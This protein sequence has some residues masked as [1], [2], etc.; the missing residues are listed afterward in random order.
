MNRN[1]LRVIA[2]FATLAV[3]AL[4]LAGCGGDEPATA[5][6]PPAPPPAPPP[7]QPQPVEVALGE[8]GGTV[9]LMTVE[10]GGF[11]L[12]G[13]AFE[14]GAENPVE[15]EGG[16]M[17]ALTLA[18]GAWT[19]A[20]VPM[21]IMVALGA[22]EESVTL[23]TVE[24]GGYTM[25]GM[26]VESGGTATS[27]A[28]ASYTL[29]MAEDGTWTA[30]FAP[31]T[32]SVPLGNSGM[33]VE[34]VSNEA[35]MWTVG[36]AALKGDGTDTYMSEGRTYSLAMEDGAWT[37]AFVPMTQDVML[38]TSGD[39]V[40]LMTVES[41]GW[42]MGDSSV[43][44]GYMTTAANGNRY[45]LAMVAGEW[46]ATFQPASVAV[47]L[48]GSGE[49]ATLMT[50]E[51]G[52]WT[53]NGMAL[54]EAP[55]AMNSAGESYSLSMEDGEWTAM[56]VP[57]SQPVT[58]GASGMS[59][60][61]MTDE[62]GA[63]T[64]DGDV[65]DTGATVAGGANAAT[66][67]AN[68]Y[69][70]TLRDDGTWGAAYQPATMPIGDT[71]LQARAKEDG[72]GYDVGDT[73]S[74]DADGMGE[75]TGPDG[76]MFRVMMDADGMLAGVRY[77]LDMANTAMTAD[78]KEFTAGTANAA[79]TLIGNDRD[80]PENEK[81]TRLSALRESFSMGE[82]LGG[83][84]ATE[85][86]A[87]IVA[88]AR[89]EMVKIRD[90]VAQLV[91]LR[92]DDGITDTAFT[93]QIE[94]QW[95]KA[96]D[97]IQDIFGGS[98]QLERTLS[99]SRVVDAFDRLVDALSSE[100]NFLA[101]SLAN[102]PDK[103]QGFHDRTA[104]NV[105]A[106]FNRLESTATARLGALRST[107]FGA[108]VFNST[109]NAKA[110]Y[111]TAEAAQAFAWSTM[112][113]IRRATD[114]TASGE[115]TY[116][117]QTLAAD[118]AGN[119]YS[120][121][122]NLS[123][124]LTRMNVDGFVTQLA[125]ADTQAP[126]TQ[127]LGGEVVGIHFPTAALNTRGR[128]HVES[129]AGSTNTGR[130]S[131]NPQ[132]GGQPDEDLD[133]GATFTGQLLGRG[134]LSGEEAIGTWK[135]A[136]GSTTLAGGFGAVRGSDRD[137]PGTTVTGDLA[138]IGKRGSV[139]S[140]SETGPAALPKIEA[141]SDATPPVTAAQAR[142]AIGR[143]TV[144]DT[145][146]ANFKYV[147]RPRDTAAEAADADSD[148]YVVGNYTVNRATVLEADEHDATKGNWVA[149]ARAEIVK[150]LNQLRRILD[151]DNADASA[152]DRK[153]ANDQR[154][155]LFDEIQ[156]ELASVFGPGRA[157]V[158]AVE[159]SS[160]GAGDGVAA[161]AEIYTGV[162]TREDGAALG[163]TDAWSAHTDYPVNS[164]GVAQD[165][166]VIAEIEDVLEALGAADAFADA[167]DTGGLFAAAKDSRIDPYPGAAAIFGRPRG[168]LR[169]AT[170]ATNYTRLGAW[171]HQ[172]S[173]YAADGLALQTYERADP[174]RV[175]LG[176]FAYSPLDPTAA[177]ASASHRLYPAAGAAGTVRA[178]YAGRT[179]AAQG[180]IFY[181]GAVEARVFWDPS[182]VE[183][184]QVTVTLTDLQDADS[185]DP[186]QFGY[187]GSDPDDPDH[188]AGT[189]DVESLMWTA[190]IMQEDGVVKL[191]SSDDVTVRVNTVDGAPNYRPAY[192]SGVRGMNT[193]HFDTNP[194]QN[195]TEGNNDQ[196]RIG[197]SNTNYWVLEVGTGSDDYGALA[198]AAID[199]ERHQRNS[200][201]YAT[202]S[203]TAHDEA[204]AAFLAGLDTLAYPTHIVQGVN[205]RPAGTNA[206]TRGS[207]ILLFKDGSTLHI[208]RYFDHNKNPIGTGTEDPDDYEAY[209]LP[210][211]PLLSADNNRL[212]YNDL[213]QGWSKDFLTEDGSG[214]EIG[215]G[216]PSMTPGQLA[217]AFLRAGGY[218]NLLE[219]DTTA[220]DSSLNG[221]FV[222]QD[223][224]GPLG[225]IGN[226]T[227]TGG[228]FGVG[229]ERGVIRGAFGADI[230][231]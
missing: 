187:A 230:Q 218:V 60:T 65:V 46:Q 109:P 112:D 197:T 48:G 58:L 216:A 70:L 104:G 126:W 89:A 77:D 116:A 3:L 95:S 144:L 166:S 103:L 152:G 18:D 55:M 90:R 73:M 160:P 16:R 57:R 217:A 195:P 82:L 182:D 150:K 63:W 139:F 51:D 19:A 206:N 33:S 221:M 115:A 34:L 185:G 130:L 214:N 133:P 122:I 28:G 107:R 13:E 131:Y 212:L 176:A 4:G 21:E 148:E 124:R 161:V 119:L 106:T 9:T 147:P 205:V 186:L 165:A 142:P 20:F 114:M 228:A 189:T 110:A 71:G 56:H 227:L 173:D 162:L 129:K 80:T 93:A 87:N 50:A 98:Q 210:G 49:F 175:E 181:T 151:L 83:G 155:R 203:G 7:F 52:T 27:S 159:E 26:P 23:T 213:G 40:T 171:R 61:L 226:W 41:G 231:P 67:E 170:A 120:G 156:T 96:D 105:G 125:R 168:R 219:T 204:E 137:L 53:M 76:G 174:D 140:T 202:T 64:M 102:G 24:A 191:A 12:N 127:G 68:M 158:A 99:A 229:V 37:A 31:M 154:Q 97:Q 177:Y 123:V 69:A 220:R 180:D 62:A 54:G 208:D 183:D 72:T 153:F 11:T 198:W 164:A 192:G 94:N 178:T 25:G 74:L 207:S 5:A 47:M 225:I 141:D 38:G 78:A 224:D 39:T 35:G 193:R 135:I 36:G 118:Q 134:D 215:A 10:G 146:N 14:G 167:L 188:V 45:T 91:A 132:A 117:G 111:G 172:V 113:N 32:R 8:S 194:A 84:A 145:S 209:R 66:G 201:N 30:M 17:Y 85:T 1:P 44:D 2:L 43:A 199:T 59:V 15:G 138:A 196:L 29:T 149:D 81:N 128:W 6:T 200:G 211:T 92:A 86:G 223:Q 108:A 101:A 42:A 75:I 222:G 179:A 169:M 184:S 163:A 79:P 143:S 100:E 22:S 136:M 88:K 121:S 190:E 157:A